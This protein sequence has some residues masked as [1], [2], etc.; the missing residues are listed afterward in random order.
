MKVVKMAESK[1]KMCHKCLKVK[2]MEEFPFMVTHQNCR[3]SICRH[4]K[5]VMFAPPRF[6]DSAN[7]Y[8]HQRFLNKVNCYNLTDQYVNSKIRMQLSRIKATLSVSSKTINEIPP[9]LTE[10]KRQLILVNRELRSK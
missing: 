3:D 6:T 9:E 1:T 5:K 8:E 4:C 10:L 7:P 2:K